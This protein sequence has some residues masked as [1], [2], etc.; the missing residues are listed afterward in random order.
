[1]RHARLAALVLLAGCASVETGP[2]AGVAGRWIGQCYSCPV[3]EFTLVLAQEGQQ[4]TGTLQ[5]AGRSGLGESP[6]ALLDGR[7]A[8]RTVKFRTLGADGLPLEVSLDVSK[9][10]QS[11]L[12]KA[13]HRAPFGVRFSRAGR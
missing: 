5:A 6:M 13:E 9:D 10:G 8:G 12:G 11:L 7:V 3:R 1:M 2:P 4:L